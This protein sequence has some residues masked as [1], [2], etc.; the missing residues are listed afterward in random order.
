MKSTNW[1]AAVQEAGERAPARAVREIELDLLARDA[2]RGRRRWS[3]RS[4]CRSRR[5]RQH[6][7]ER[8]LAERTLPGDRSARAQPAASRDRPARE[9]QREPEAAARPPA[10]AATARSAR[11]RA[12]A[13]ASG[14]EPARPSRPR[15]PSQS[16]NT[17]SAPPAASAD[18]GSAAFRPPRVTAPPLPTTRSR[19]PRSAPALACELGVASLE[20]S[21]ATHSAAPGNAVR[22][23][24]Q[25]RRDPVGLVA[26][27]DHD[28]SAR[29]HRGGRSAAL[30]IVPRQV[31][32]DRQMEER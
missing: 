19:A 9:A 15:S 25:R 28:A 18:L 22:E 6:V 27:R 30:S 20:P 10:K 17:S 26:G 3:F 2:R 31:V 4:P 23:R 24:R 32:R 13:L 11:P 8:L 14:A 21:S 7:L 1:P 5:Q 16:T 29:E 12:T